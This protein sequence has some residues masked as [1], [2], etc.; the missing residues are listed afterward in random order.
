M[1]LDTGKW[2]VQLHSATLNG[3]RQRWADTAQ[4]PDELSLPAVVFLHGWPESWYSWR[5]Q[6]LLVRRAGYRGIAPDMRGYG[7]TDAPAEPALYNVHTLASDVLAL[8]QHLRVPRVALVGHDHGANLGW[9]LCLLHPDSFACYCAMSVPYGGRE[10]S[11]ALGIYRERFGNESEIEKDPDFFYM[12]HHQLPGAAADYE[13]D[14]RAALRAIFGSRS[15]S[16]SV[17]AAP[18]Q[19]SKLYVGGK[20]EALW[21]RLPQPTALRGWLSEHDL[22]YFAQE[23][24][25]RGWNGGLNWYRVMDTDWHLTPHLSGQR[26]QQPV[27]F[28]AGSKDIVMV[29]LGGE[30]NVRRRLN[31]SCA[32][33]RNF[34]IIPGAGHWIQQE[35]SEDVNS[36]L[37][38]FLSENFPALPVR[39]SGGGSDPRSRL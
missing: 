11:P 15:N 4:D 18:V 21:R 2:G 23:F 14:T 13:Q 7:G 17:D 24:E 12:L 33:L 16:A 25:R 10:R 34:K 35:C 19:S 39:S 31:K 6:L 1:S 37:L 22:D 27:S 9:K 30:E 5:H 20:S 29:M 3:I 28:I 32:D 8:L 26:V 36:F 38:D